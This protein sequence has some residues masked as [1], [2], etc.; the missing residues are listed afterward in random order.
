MPMV[1]L[2]YQL[3][4]AII[5]NSPKGILSGTVGAVGNFGGVIYAIIFRYHGTNYAQVFWIIGIMMIAMNLMF[6]WVK[7]LPSGQIGGR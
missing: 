1:S 5:A 4:S 6:V 3:S 2:L 7:P